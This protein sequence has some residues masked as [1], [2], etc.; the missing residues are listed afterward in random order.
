MEGGETSGVESGSVITHKAP[1]VRCAWADVAGQIRAQLQPAG[2]ANKS[3]KAW[4]VS[5]AQE[6][7]SRVSLAVA[8]ARQLD[9]DKAKDDA[10]NRKS[11]WCGVCAFL[12]G[13]NSMPMVGC[14]MLVMVCN[15]SF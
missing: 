3:K 14:G 9:A 11:V 13:R 4:R 1:S 5:L 10:E 8:D 15:V 6:G 2:N 7:T 12:N